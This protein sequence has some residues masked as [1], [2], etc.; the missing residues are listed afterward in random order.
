MNDYQRRP[1]DKYI[2]ESDWAEIYELK[3]HWKSDLL[4]YKDELRFFRWLIDNYFIGMTLGEN[5]DAVRELEMDLLEN[6]KTCEDLI[7]K[8]RKHIIQLGETAKDSENKP[9]RVFRMEHENLED[10]ISR[11]A[12]KFKIIRKDVMTVTEYVLKSE[13]WMDL[14]SRRIKSNIP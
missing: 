14:K 6:D 9:T 12:Q 11:F 2:Q 13:H 1:K 7:R 8:V 5:L 3:Q 4:L 10:H